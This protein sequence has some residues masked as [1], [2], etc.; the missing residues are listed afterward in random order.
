MDLYIG[1][2]NPAKITQLASALAPGGVV[3]QPLD[4][5]TLPP[6]AEDT[7]V[8][9]N[10]RAKATAFAAAASQPVLAMD[11]GLGFPDLADEYQPGTHVRRVP[12]VGGRPSDEQ[13][14]THYS[15]LCAEHG[16]SIRAVW[17][18]G[19]AIGLPDGRSFGAE[20][21]VERQMV[22]PASAEG[23]PGY[24]LD[25]LQKD[26]VTGR[27]ISEYSGIDAQEMWHRTIGTPLLSFVSATMASIT[28]QPR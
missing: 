5:S 14:L 20:T 1:T 16:G 11:V 12:G 15:R 7:D 3:L 8:V 22:T 24:P 23:R 21:A 28:T 6:V 9:G 10:A 25:S 13:V 27:F 17:S 26:P 2:T 4:P 19:F 18:Y